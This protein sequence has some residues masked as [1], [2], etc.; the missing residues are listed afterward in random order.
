MIYPLIQHTFLSGQEEDEDTSVL[1]AET[2]AL[3]RRVA[4]VRRKYRRCVRAWV[5]DVA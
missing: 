5:V 1:E 2:T 3:Y 4:D